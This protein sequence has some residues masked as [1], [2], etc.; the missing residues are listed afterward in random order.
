VTEA[1]V[2]ILRRLL[3]DRYDD[4]KRS[5]TRRLGSPEM[6]TSSMIHGCVWR[7]RIPRLAPC[8]I[9][10]AIC[11]RKFASCPP[12]AAQPRPSHRKRLSAKAR[13]RRVRRPRSSNARR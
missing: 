10:A 13:S 1:P 8:T 4:L 6:A 7:A 11:A 9:R 3:L 12:K 2:A 5:L